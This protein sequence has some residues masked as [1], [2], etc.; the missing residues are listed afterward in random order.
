MCAGRPLYDFPREPVGAG[1]LT[2]GL[3]IA[4]LIK[5]ERPKVALEH[6]A[7]GE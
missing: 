2:S 5:G 6:T 1:D 3:F 4:N 7:S